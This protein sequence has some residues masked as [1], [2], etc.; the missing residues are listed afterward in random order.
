MN[1]AQIGNQKLREQLDEVTRQRDTNRTDLITERFDRVMKKY[2]KPNNNLEA[3]ES[4]SDDAND[5]LNLDSTPS[6]EFQNDF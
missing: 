6:D 3:S 1:L 2:N 5:K 4:Q